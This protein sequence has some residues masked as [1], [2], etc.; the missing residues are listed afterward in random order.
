MG[1]S[2]VNGST[3]VSK[4]FLG[5]PSILEGNVLTCK[6]GGGYVANTEVGQTRVSVRGSR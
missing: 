1:R 4:I 3:H 5:P 2:V 6:A